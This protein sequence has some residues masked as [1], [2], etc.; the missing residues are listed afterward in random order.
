MRLA[1]PFVA[2]GLA[3]R[4][5]AEPLSLRHLIGGVLVVAGAAGTVLSG[6]GRRL[7]AEAERGVT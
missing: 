4:L 1:Q 3:W 7:R 6:D 5:L 2:G